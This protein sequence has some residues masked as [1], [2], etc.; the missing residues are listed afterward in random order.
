MTRSRTGRSFPGIPGTSHGQRGAALLIALIAVALASVI[1]LG[2]IER[3]QHSLART[4]ALMN[5]ERAWQYARGMEA[6]A[7]ETLRRVR[8]EGMGS[9]TVDGTW[10]T[11]FEVPGGHVQGRL[12][13][14]NARFNVNALAHPDAA[15][16]ASSHEA[17]VRLLDSLGLDTVIADELADWIDGA[18][19]PRPGSAADDWYMSLD[20]PYRTAGSILAHASELRWLRSVDEEA[21]SALAPVVTALPQ[22]ELVVNVNTARIHVLASLFEQMDVDQARRVLADG[23]FSDLQAFRSHP[24]VQAAVRPGLEQHLSVD[25]RWYLA[26]ARVNLDGVERDFFRLLSPAGPGY[27]E[28]RYFSQGVP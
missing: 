7:D 5:N 22:P 15:L 25:G 9:D 28:F 26:Q 2:L 13:D 11:P 18:I 12:L 3:G 4:E 20:P 27:D 16:A 17:F 14:Q 19:M 6:L 8:A 21:W 23:P 1:A 10:T 24:L